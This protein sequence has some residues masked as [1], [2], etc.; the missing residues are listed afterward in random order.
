MVAEKK[1]GFFMKVLKFLPAAGRNFLEVQILL[2]NSATLNKSF[3]QA[4]H[5]YHKP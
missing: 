1:L 5:L 4:S 3:L 2:G